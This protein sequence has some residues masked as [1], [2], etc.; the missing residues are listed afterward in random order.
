M[1]KMSNMYELMLTNKST[2]L[3]PTDQYRG[4]GTCTIQLWYNFCQRY[5]AFSVN[6][7]KSFSSGKKFLVF[8]TV[9]DF[10]IL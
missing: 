5:N 8:F 3:A 7:K 10:I 6:L 2:N 1:I 4:R 9:A